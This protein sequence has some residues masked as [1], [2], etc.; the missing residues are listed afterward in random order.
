[1]VKLHN[2]TYQTL[3]D[4]GVHVGHSLSNSHLFTLWSAY[5]YIQPFNLIFINLFKTIIQARVGFLSLASALETYSPIW[6]VD[7]DP[8]N[9]H[10]TEFVANSCGEFYWANKWVHGALSNFRTIMSLIIR[11]ENMSRKWHN[12]RQKWFVNDLR[13]WLRTR[14]TWPRALFA[15][16]VHTTQSPVKEAFFLGIPCF[17]IVDTNAYCIL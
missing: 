2:L 15:Q 9:K 1:M 8:V 3:L 17:G 12:T 7:L 13:Y 16:S 14:T 5:L 11:L 4:I 10:Y 6:F